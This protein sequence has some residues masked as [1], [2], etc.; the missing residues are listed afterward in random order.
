MCLQIKPEERPS[1]DD[2]RNHINTAN[3]IIVE[4]FPLSLSQ[5][6]A[7]EQF[8]QN[9]ALCKNNVTELPENDGTSACTFLCLKIA[10]KFLELQ[11]VSEE[12]FAGQSIIINFSEKKYFSKLKLL[13]C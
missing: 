6:T 9:I 12:E 13:N 8:D 1:L 4:K 5:A 3:E 11:P 10:E 2:L 7:L